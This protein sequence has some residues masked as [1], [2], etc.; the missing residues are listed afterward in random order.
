MGQINLFAATLTNT[1]RDFLA[2]SGD[3]A[4]R[5]VGA[6]RVLDEREHPHVQCIDDALEHSY[7]LLE[8]ADPL[9][10]KDIEWLL[11]GIL[12]EEYPC[13]DKP[14]LMRYAIA[15]AL[16]PNVDIMNKNIR[17]RRAVEEKNKDAEWAAIQLF[18][19]TMEHGRMAFRYLKEHRDARKS[20]HFEVNRVGKIILIEYDHA[21]LPK[22]PRES[23]EP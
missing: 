3:E 5:R 4:L 16:N 1:M 10:M 20:T 7:V 2:N 13:D 14:L 6:I 17:I 11:R 15:R 12:W 9:E 21:N 22:K 23:K 18:R 19:R 8:V